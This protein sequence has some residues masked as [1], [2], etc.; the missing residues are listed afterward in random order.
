MRAALPLSSDE[1]QAK[2]MWFTMSSKSGQSK[3]S[4]RNQPGRS[5]QRWGAREYLALGRLICA[6][7]RWICDFDSMD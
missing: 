3:R 7:G 1:E 5:V 6:L 2:G 4:K